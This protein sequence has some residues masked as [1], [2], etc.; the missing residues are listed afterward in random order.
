MKR[1]WNEEHYENSALAYEKE[2]FIHGTKGEVDFIENEINYDKQSRILDVGCGTGRHS[3]ELARRGYNYIIG[4]DLSSSMIERAKQIADNEQLLV[5]FLVEDACQLKYE[6]EFD[7]VIMLCEGA[8]SIVESDEKDIQIMQ[9][10]HTAMKPKAKLIMTCGNALYQIVNS[11]GNKFNL[12]TF[13]ESFKLESIDDD[14]N[15]KELDC[16]Q[17]Y[18]VHSE[19]RYIMTNIGFDVI[20]IYNSE[21]GNYSRDT[22]LTEDAF[23]MLVIAT[24]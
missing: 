11:K 10:I 21:L 20:G 16:N 7:L 6:N 15:I 1:P 18:Y 3:I 17:R 13:R 22:K 2:S 14:G 19:L 24:K 5:S 4:V 12:S 8:F 9:G 23:E